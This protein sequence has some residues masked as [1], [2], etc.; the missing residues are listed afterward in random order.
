MAFTN[1]DYTITFQ[2]KI[3]LF[4]SNFFIKTPPFRFVPPLQIYTSI[5]FHIS[6]YIHSFLLC[7]FSNLL[8]HIKFSSIPLIYSNNPFI[9]SDTHSPQPL[10]VKLLPPNPQT[11]LRYDFGVTIN[12][13][14]FIIII[15]CF[16]FT[17]ISQRY[18]KKNNIFFNRETR[19]SLKEVSTKN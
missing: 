5:V 2:I 13:C 10:T 8:L 15:Y 18:L 17:D 14:Y 9:C 1:L 6:V 3:Y 7:N 11:I 12:E 16:C 19:Q 4:Y